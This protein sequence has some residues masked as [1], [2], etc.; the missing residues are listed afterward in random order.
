MSAHPRLAI[1]GAGP[2]G[3]EAAL[4]AAEHGWDFTVYEAAPTA[5]G[6]VRDWGHTRMFTPWSMNVSD[7]AR[8]ALGDAA[9]D[10]DELPTGDELA[11]RVLDPLAAR[12]RDRVRLGTRVVAV[13]REGLL[14]HEEIATPARTAHPFRL[15]VQSGSEERVEHADAV[16][17]CTGTYGNPNALGDGGIPAPGERTLAD[18]IEHRLPRRAE[19]WAGR[20]VLLTG[21]GHSAQTAALA[22]A[23]LARDAPGTRIVWAV[24]SSDPTWFAVD[25][26][27]LPARAALT[28]GA[29]DLA[30]GASPAVDVRLGRVTEALR[31]DGERVAVTLRNGAAEEVVVDR[32]LAL[33]GGV[34]DH[35]LYRQLQV[36]ECYA[37]AAPMKLSAALLGADA[38]GDC[39]AA[40]SLGPEVLLSPEPGFF[41][42][43]AKSYGRNSQFVMRV[44]WEQV[45]DAFGLLA[46]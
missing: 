9:P 26:D 30:A 20:T 8:R 44:G 13:G 37:T 40:P 6:H 14:K 5:A 15:L 1:L 29:R 22:L 24:R 17:D 31:A 32:V 45:D 38:G 42:L 11:D 7:R 27:P 19:S 28:R 3:L 46:R 41:I 34:G 10:G 21:A 2:I 4:A 39:L 43:G 36:H 18:R 23:E 16:I 12:L 25:D 33:T 35:T